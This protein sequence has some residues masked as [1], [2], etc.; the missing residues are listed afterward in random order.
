MKQTQLFNLKEEYIDFEIELTHEFDN[1]FFPISVLFITE[2]T[3]IKLNKELFEVKSGN[4][5]FIYLLSD[6][7]KNELNSKEILSLLFENDKPFIPTD[8][9]VKIDTF[10]IDNDIEFSAESNYALAA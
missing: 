10:N 2:D 9:N 6:L 7:L 3:S 1:K 4:Q 5:H 8:K